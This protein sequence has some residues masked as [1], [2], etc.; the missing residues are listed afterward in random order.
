LVAIAPDDK[1]NSARGDD[2][3][4]QVVG[5]SDELTNLHIVSVYD[6]QP[7][8]VYHYQVRSMALGG[9]WAKSKDFIF[10][11]KPQ[12]LEIS[13]YTVEKING[14]TAIFRWLTTAETDAAVKYA[15]Y[16]NGVLAVDSALTVKNK[17][18]STMHEVTV[19]GFESGT[20]YEVELSGRDSKNNTI[21]KKISSF[22]TG[23]DDLPPEIYQIQTESALSTGKELSTQ[24]V[25]SWLT[26]EPATGQVFYQSGAGTPNE[27][28]WEKTPLDTNYSKKH[29]IVITKFE[30]GAIYQFKIQSADS[31][32]NIASSKSFTILMPRQKESV[33]QVIMKNFE[34]IFGWTRGL[35]R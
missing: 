17:N 26:N 22:S 15:P 6:L 2:G 34:E 1:Y 24:T 21:A 8:T 29:I 31:N 10:K 32:N 16:R 7:E 3:Y 12:E 30:P 19:E 27:E 14:S 20:L 35:S 4:L 25:I 28:A 9:A 23:E 5:N 18:F 11:T 13:T 33:F